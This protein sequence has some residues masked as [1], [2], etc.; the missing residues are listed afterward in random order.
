MTG[1]DPDASD[2][3]ARPTNAHVRVPAGL[4]R[5]IESRLTETEFESVDE[6]VAFALDAVL[7]Q[8]DERDDDDGDRDR[9]ADGVGGDAPHDDGAMQER[10]ESLGYL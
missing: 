7:R 5:K 8:I 6:Y 2:R 10:L 4:R 3:G 1:R 9:A